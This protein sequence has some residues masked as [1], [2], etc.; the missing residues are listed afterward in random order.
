[1]AS[2]KKHK[3]V[4]FEPNDKRTLLTEPSGQEGLDA[5][6][7]RLTDQEKE[8]LARMKELDGELCAR[9]NDAFLMRFIWARKFDVERSIELLRAHMEWRR[10]YQVRFLT[11]LAFHFLLSD[12]G[13]LLL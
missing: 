8:A 12:F 5:F 7:Q 9:W 6:F 11:F 10:E 4:T 13:Q 1:M 3:K 2:T